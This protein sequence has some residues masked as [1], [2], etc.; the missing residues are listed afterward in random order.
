MGLF[1]TTKIIAP[2]TVWLYLP[3]SL[4]FHESICISQV[5]PAALPQP[6]MVDSGP[7]YRESSCWQYVSGPGEV[8]QR[9]SLNSDILL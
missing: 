3:R 2:A 9:E 5:K 1:N 6:E 8:D 7:V 4:L